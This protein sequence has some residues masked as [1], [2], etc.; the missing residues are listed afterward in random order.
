MTPGCHDAWPYPW[1]HSD[2]PEATHDGLATHGHSRGGG[3][4]ADLAGG[5]HSSGGWPA[6]EL[7]GAT[8]DH[9]VA[10]TWPK[11]TGCSLAVQAAVM[12]R[13]CWCPAGGGPQRAGARRT[14]G[15]CAEEVG[16]ELHG[17]RGSDNRGAPCAGGMQRGRG[18]WVQARGSVR[19]WSW[20][21]EGGS[22]CRV[23]MAD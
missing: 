23:E 14:R 13:R 8:V 21:R 4:P 11:A 15:D 17:Q 1:V 7:H 16:A 6:D 22:R 20:L 18:P 10:T 12:T 9:G 19:P 3:T 2:P 5:G